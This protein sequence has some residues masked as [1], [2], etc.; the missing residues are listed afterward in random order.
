MSLKIIHT[1]QEMREFVKAKKAKAQNESNFSECTLG[2]VPTMGALHEGH[3]S[4]IKRAKTMC[5]A[6]VVSIFVNPTQFS[7]NEDFSI[8]PR[9]LENDVKLLESLG[10]DAVFAPSASEMYPEGDNKNNLT[11]VCPPYDCVDKLCGKSR[12]G[13][14]DGVATV[15]SKLFNIVQPDYAFFGQKDAQQLFIIKKTVRDLNFGVKIV[16]CPIVREQSGLALSSRN[17]YLSGEEKIKA[18]NISKAL[19]EIK[20]LYKSGIKDKIHLEDTALAILKNLK[21][22]YLEFLDEETFEQNDIIDDRTIVLIAAYAGSTRLIDN[23]I[24]GD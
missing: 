16:G 14:F 8:Y 23:I 20:R 21:V 24:L 15:V 9:T 6:V 17:S 22:E 19:F 11:L 1:I 18:L 13:H 10:V 2:L 7:A 5:R 3:L 12:I 4:L